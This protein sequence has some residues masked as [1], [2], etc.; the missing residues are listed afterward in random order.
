MNVSEM[1]HFESGRTYNFN[2]INQSIYRSYHRVLLAMA[3]CR[4]ALIAA[5]KSQQIL[6]VKCTFAAVVT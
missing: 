3:I 4:R 5:C 1:T 2:S 6:Y